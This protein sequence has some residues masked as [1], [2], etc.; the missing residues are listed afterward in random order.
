MKTLAAVLVKKKKIKILN[1]DLPDLK[2]GQ[3]LVKMK[4]SSICHTQIQEIDGS[5]GKDKFLPHCLGHEATGLV[6]KIGKGVKKVKPRDKVCLS[7]V[8]SSGI[9]AGGTTYYYNKNTGETSW[10]KPD[11]DVSQAFVPA[12]KLF[13]LFL[14]QDFFLILPS[15]MMKIT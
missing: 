12:T 6:I 13:N 5:R 8:P 14:K 15:Q 9:N 4:F 2:K 11:A 7:W 3:I 10:E 1:L